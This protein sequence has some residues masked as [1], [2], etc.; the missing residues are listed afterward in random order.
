MIVGSIKKLD[1]LEGGWTW[2]VTGDSW[3]H[4]Q[5]EVHS[6][7]AC[8]RN[9]LT[10]HGSHIMLGWTKGYTAKNSLR[11]G[12]LLL[13]LAN[14]PLNSC[15]LQESSNTKHFG[16]ELDLA[17]QSHISAHAADLSHLLNMTAVT[18]AGYLAFLPWL[19]YTHDFFPWWHSHI[20]MW[21]NPHLPNRRWPGHCRTASRVWEGD[22][23]GQHQCPRVR[24]QLEVPWP[25][26][27]LYPA[28]PNI[29]LSTQL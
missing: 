5:E 21:Q 4:G 16:I 13:S 29:L 20:L 7:C 23:L 18:H 28:K 11:V 8:N 10:G 22:M 14:P 15:R 3:M 25:G 26:S 2:E 6:C 1:L 27:S 19:G 12:T 9:Q 24:I 17:V